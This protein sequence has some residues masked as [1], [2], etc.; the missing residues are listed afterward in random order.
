MNRLMSS[1][2]KFN[3]LKL[4][5]CAMGPLLEVMQSILTFPLVGPLTK[6]IVTTFPQLFQLPRD[7]L[8]TGILR[9]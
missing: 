4:L 9:T 2:V 5:A 7:I 3:R 1:L 8:P 6:W